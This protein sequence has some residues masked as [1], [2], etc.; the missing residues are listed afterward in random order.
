VFKNKGFLYGL[1]VGLILGACLL[2]LMNFAVLDNKT[3]SSETQTPSPSPSPSISPATAPLASI[4]PFATVKAAKPTE[5][6][7]APDKPSSAPVST[8]AITKTEEP[9]SPTPVTALADPAGSTIHIESGMTSSE[10]ASLLFDK[11]TITDQKAFDNALSHLKLDRIIR[12]V[13][14]TFLPDEKYED[15]INKITT[16]K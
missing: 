16:H 3:I 8:P 4:E 9:A 10:V 14:L 11:G 2:Q 13:T 7:N 12:V 6:T 1:G 15:I 5:T